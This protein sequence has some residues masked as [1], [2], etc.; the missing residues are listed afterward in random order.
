MASEAGVGYLNLSSR[1]VEAEQVAC[2]WDFRLSPSE[3][4]CARGHFLG[5]Q[6][7]GGL[8]PWKGT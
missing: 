8:Q 3:Q 4:S 6:V 5:L 1:G 2:G 7:L